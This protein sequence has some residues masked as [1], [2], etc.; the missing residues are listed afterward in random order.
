MA[1]T[2]GKQVVPSALKL[3]TLEGAWQVLEQFMTQEMTA[4]Q[5][6]SSL[7]TKL[8]T[9][10]PS[11]GL[12]FVQQLDT[13]LPSI[14]TLLDSKLVPFTVMYLFMYNTA[15]ALIDE[16]SPKVG[17]LLWVRW[18]LAVERYGADDSKPSLWQ[19]YDSR[20]VQDLPDLLKNCVEVMEHHK[21]CLPKHLALFFALSFFANF[22]QAGSIT[23]AYFS[24][25]NSMAN[26]IAS[27]SMQPWAESST[28]LLPIDFFLLSF[29]RMHKYL[30][31]KYRKSNNMDMLESILHTIA[32][33]ASQK[34]WILSKKSAATAKT[35]VEISAASS[36]TPSALEPSSSQVEIAALTSSVWSRE[37]AHGD[38]SAFPPLVSDALNAALLEKR[39]SLSCVVDGKSLD[40]K[41]LDTDSPFC[42]DQNDALA[43]F[44]VRKDLIFESLD[45]SAAEVEI[46]E[47][48]DDFES[49][50]LLSTP[51]EPPI[52][53]LKIIFQTV[54]S[55]VTS[56]ELT[57][58]LIK[59]LSTKLP[60]LL[61][62]SD[63]TDVL[64]CL[65][66]IQ[67]LSETDSGKERRVGLETLRVLLTPLVSSMLHS[68]NVT[69]FAQVFAYL[70]SQPQ[71]GHIWRDRLQKIASDVGGTKNPES[72]AR[73]PP[74][75]LATMKSSL[76]STEAT[77]Q[78]VE[79]FL[80]ASPSDKLALLSRNPNFR[81]MYA[82]YLPKSLL[83]ALV[84][85]DPIL[86][87]LPWLDDMTRS[88]E[89]EQLL[90]QHFPA[91]KN[92]T[93][94]RLADV[95]ALLDRPRDAVNPLHIALASIIAKRALKNVS[96][97][98]S[99]AL[100]FI[101]PFNTAIRDFADPSSYHDHV[102]PGITSLLC[103]SLLLDSL[104]SF[105]IWKTQ[106]DGSIT[107]SVSRLLQPALVKL[108]PFMQWFEATSRCDLFT[109]SENLRTK[110]L[111][112]VLFRYELFKGAVSAHFQRA[113]DLNVTR[114]ELESITAAI[115]ERE[116]LQELLQLLGIDFKTVAQKTSEARL[117]VEDINDLIEMITA[118]KNWFDIVR[119]TFKPP[120]IAQSDIDKK[121]VAELVSTAQTVRRQLI[122]AG[123]THD[124][125]DQLKS[126]LL[127][128]RSEIFH[129]VF[130]EAKKERGTIPLNDL[131]NL[132]V[133]ACTHLQ[134]MFSDTSP[135]SRLKKLW[136]LIEKLGMTRLEKEL[137]QLKEIVKSSKSQIH[138]EEIKTNLESGAKLD[139]YAKV[140]PGFARF[141]HELP[142]LAQEIHN[143]KP[144]STANATTKL[145]DA[146][147]LCNQTLATREALQVK[148]IRTTLQHVS[149]V[150][151]QL[152]PHVLNFFS[153]IPKYDQLAR[154]CQRPDF[155]NKVGILTGQIQG[156]QFANDLLSNLVDV[157]SNMLS[158]FYTEKDLPA[159]LQAVKTRIGGLTREQLEIKLSKFETLRINFGEIMTY[160]SGTV[161][162]SA[163]A[164]LPTAIRALKHGRYRANASSS[165][166]DIDIA[167]EQVNGATGKVESTLQY[168]NLHGRLRSMT[169]FVDRT[170][171]KQEQI[172]ALDEFK[173]C[174]DLALRVAALH[175][176]LA[177]SGHPAFQANHF[178]I[179]SGDH[180]MTTAGYKALMESLKS[181]SI[182]WDHQIASA[183]AQ[184]RRLL[185]LT[186]KAIS[187]F[188]RTLH[189]LFKTKAMRNTVYEELLPY[190]ALAF[191]EL[192]SATSG[193]L[194]IS[195]K[196][197]VDS[198]LV[199]PS[200]EI[201]EYAFDLENP[202]KEDESL[203]FA[204]IL[205]H[206]ASMLARLEEDPEVAQAIEKA[207]LSNPGEPIVIRAGGLTQI[208]LWKTV[209]KALTAVPHPSQLLY[210]SRLTSPQ[211]LDRFLQCAER[212]PKI[213]FVIYGVNELS[214][215]VRHRLLNWTS[216]SAS[217][218]GVCGQ[219]FLLFTADRSGDDMFG[220]LHS[221]AADRRAFEIP[222]KILAARGI[223][224]IHCLHSE[225]GKSTKSTAYFKAQ[226][227]QRTVHISISEEFEV[228]SVFN[229]LDDLLFA[230][231]SKHAVV[232][233][234]LDIKPYADLAMVTRFLNDWLYFG[235]IRDPSTGVAHY[236]L[237]RQ[238]TIFDVGEEEAH[239]QPPVGVTWHFVIELTN[240]APEDEGFLHLVPSE[241]NSI[242]PIL[243][244]LQS[245]YHLRSSE[246]LPKSPVVVTSEMRLLAAIIRSF[247]G[248]AKTFACDEKMGAALRD[249]AQVIQI[250]EQEF[251]H[252]PSLR[253]R[254]AVVK[255]LSSV[256]VNFCRWNTF[257]KS[258]F[259]SMLY[260]EYQH[261]NQPQNA[262]AWLRKIN[263]ARTVFGMLL[264]EAEYLTSTTEDAAPVPLIITREVGKVSELDHRTDAYQD[265]M[266]PLMP[267]T[268]WYAIS[269]G[270]PDQ[271]LTKR[272]PL[273][274]KFLNS[275]QATQS[276]LATLTK[277]QSAEPNKEF[278]PSALEIDAR[279]DLR[280]HMRTMVA[281]AMGITNTGKMI[282]MLE[283][284]KYVLTPNLSH[285]M[286][287]LNA[288][289]A[290]G[291][292]VILVG[293]T[294]QGKTEMVNFF[295]LFLNMDNGSIPDL[296]EE[297]ARLAC[298][299]IGHMYS[300]PIQGHPKSLDEKQ[301]TRAELLRLFQDIALSDRPVELPPPIAPA[302][303]SSSPNLELSKATLIATGAASSSAAPPPKYV[304]DVR[305]FP[306]LTQAEDDDNMD[307]CWSD[308][309]ATLK[310]WLNRMFR[311]YPL[312]EQSPLLLQIEQGILRNADDDEGFED[313]HDDLSDAGSEPEAREMSVRDLERY[314]STI[315]DLRIQNLFFKQ[316]IYRGLP[317][318]ALTAEIRKAVNAAK[319]HPQLKVLFFLDESNTTA[320][321]GRLKELIVDHRWGNK[322][323]PAN[324]S[325]VAAINPQKIVRT[326]GDPN[327]PMMQVDFAQNNAIANVVSN[328]SRFDVRLQHPSMEELVY[329]FKEMDQSADDEF[330]EAMIEL[331]DTD[332][333]ASEQR[334][335]IE[336]VILGQQQIRNAK[337]EN[338]HPSIRDLVRAM[339]L[340]KYFR[341]STFGSILLGEASMDSSSPKDLT[342]PHEVNPAPFSAHFW[343][344]L[345]MTL[346][347][348]YY[349]RLRNE[350]AAPGQKPHPSTRL[351]LLQAIN[352][353]YEQDR[354]HRR[355]E[356]AFAP[357]LDMALVFLFANTEIPPAIAPTSALMENLF[358]TV[359]CVDMKM[360]LTISGPAGCSKTL[361]FTIAVA[362]MQ[363]RGSPKPL[364]RF[365]AQ[366]HH[367]R[368]QCSEMSTDAEIDAT[369]SE[370]TSRQL[371][372]ASADGTDIREMCTVLLDEL[373]L[374]EKGSSQPLK[375]IHGKLDN[376]QV[377][378]VIL[379]NKLLDPAKTNRTLQVLQSTATSDDL[380][381]LARSCLFTQEGQH[382][383]VSTPY[384]DAIVEGTQR[385]F[386]S[387]SN[388][389][390]NAEARDPSRPLHDALCRLECF[391]LRSFVYFLRS[392]RSSCL[393]RTGHFDLTPEKLLKAILRN[394][395]G[396]MRLSD[397]ERLV[398]F[399]F[400]ELNARLKKLDGKVLPIPKIP[401]T[402]INILQES[403][404][405]VIPMHEMNPN[406]NSCRYI[407]MLDPTDSCTSLDLLFDLG[408]V[409]RDQSVIISCPEFEEDSSEKGINERVMR[410]K[411][412]M[413][414]GE[415]VILVAADGIFGNFYDLFNKHFL[416]VPVDN[417]KE[418]ES[419]VAFF[420]NVA[421][422]SISRPC[423]V[424]P[425]FKVIVHL[426]MSRVRDTP[427]PFLSRFEIY[428]LSIDHY[429]EEKK[430]HYGL[431]EV[432]HGESQLD[433]LI[434]G[435]THFWDTLRANLPGQHP[436]HGM[437]DEQTIFSLAMSALETSAHGT[438]IDPVL[439]PHFI[440]A[441][442]SDDSPVPPT[443][444][445]Y[446]AS[447][448]QHLISMTSFRLLQVAR[449]EMVT[450][451]DFLPVE[452]L[453]EYFLRQEHMSTA[454]L[455]RQL[456]SFA[457]PRRPEPSIKK[458]RKS[459]VPAEASSSDAAEPISAATASAAPSSPRAKK[460]LDLDE[461][462]NPHQHRQHDISLDT[463]QFCRK[464]VISTRS[465]GPL[466]RLHMD[467][468]V[469]SA[470]VEESEMDDAMFLSASSIASIAQFNEYLMEFIETGKT[471]LIVTADMRNR[472]ASQINDL[473]REVDN[474]LRSASTGSSRPV[475][476]FFILHHPP[477]HAQS[478]HYAY[479]AIFWNK[480]DFYYTD[481]LGVWTSEE[482][483]SDLLNPK[484]DL[485]TIAR[486]DA[487][488]WVA[489]S[490]GLDV[491]V[492]PESVQALFRGL[493]SVEF[494]SILNKQII[495]P[496]E[497]LS[498][499]GLSKKVYLIYLNAASRKKAMVDLFEQAPALIDAILTQ[500]AN[501]WSNSLLHKIVE[502]T[503]TD[504]R[505]GKATG[506]FIQ[507]IRN[508]LRFML[509]SVCKNLLTA[510]LSN[511]NMQ[512][513]YKMLEEAQHDATKDLA[514]A[515]EEFVQAALKLVPAP[516]LE[517][518]IAAS[519]LE[520][521]ESG[522]S[523][524][525]VWYIPPGK[526]VVTTLPLFDTV[527]RN[528]S[529]AIVS[530][531]RASEVS[532]I[533]LN[534][535][536]FIPAFQEELDQS[537]SLKD[538][539]MLIDSSRLLRDAFYDDFVLY[540]LE[541]PSLTDSL[542]HIV[543]VIVD[544]QVGNLERKGIQI[545]AAALF[546]IPVEFRHV[547]SHVGLCLAPLSTLNPDMADVES[548]GSQHGDS[549]QNWDPEMVESKVHAFSIGLLW[550]HLRSAT[551]VDHLDTPL[552]ETKIWQW[553]E[554]F[555]D[556]HI[557][558]TNARWLKACSSDFLVLSQYH[559]M[560]LLFEA[561][562]AF[563]LSPQELLEFVK[564]DRARDDLY[565]DPKVLASSTM[566]STRD[567]LCLIRYVRD[568]VA[569]VRAVELIA[570]G[571]PSAALR[572]LNIASDHL[573]QSIVESSIFIDFKVHESPFSAPNL[574][575]N[576]GLFMH[577]AANAVPLDRRIVFPPEI[578]RHFGTQ[579]CLGQLLGLVSKVS[580]D[581]AWQEALY[582]ASN[583]ALRQSY[584]TDSTKYSLFVPFLTAGLDALATLP[585]DARLPTQ[586]KLKPHK[587][588]H[589]PLELI[590]FQ[591]FLK[592]EKD[593]SWVELK[594]DYDSLAVGNKT[595]S[596][597]R[598]ALATSLIMRLA[599][600]LSSADAFADASRFWLDP[601]T[602][603]W[604]KTRLLSQT[605]S[606]DDLIHY[607][608]PADGLSFLFS[609]L[610]SMDAV[611]WFLAQKPL[612]ISMGL[613]DWHQPLPTG[614]Q[615][616]TRHFRWMNLN[617]PADPRYTIYKALSDHLTHDSNG[618]D[619]LI[620]AIR[621]FT[622][623]TRQP[624]APALDAP[625]PPLE[626]LPITEAER[627][628]VRLNVRMVLFMVV[629][630]KFMARGLPCP[631]IQLNFVAT[632]SPI[633]QLLDLTDLELR[634]YQ[635][636]A[637]GPRTNVHAQAEVENH[638]SQSEFDRLGRRFDF[639][640]QLLVNNMS[641]T[642]GMHR[643]S[644][645][646]NLL[647]F[648]G[649]SLTRFT[650]MVASSFR[651]HAD[652]GFISDL[653][654]VLPDAN[655]AIM[656]NVARHRLALN[657]SYWCAY[658]WSLLLDGDRVAPHAM[659]PAVHVLNYVPLK[660]KEG[661]TNYSFERAT[662]YTLAL[663]GEHPANATQS[664]AQKM[665]DPLLY[666]TE[667]LTRMQ[668]VLSSPD[669]D[670]RWKDRVAD[671]HEIGNYHEVAQR[672]VYNI[673]DGQF[674]ARAQT[675][676]DIA[677]ATDSKLKYLVELRS[678][679]TLIFSVAAPTANTI[680]LWLS[681]E[682]A[683]A[684]DGLNRR[685]LDFV[686]AY[687][688]SRQALAATRLL[689]SFVRYYES[690]S[691]VVDGRFT[692]E[693]L[694]TFS[695]KDALDALQSRKLESPEALNQLEQLT[696]A[697]IAHSKMF[698][699]LV[700]MLEGCEEG[701]RNRMFEF[702]VNEMT[703]ET[704]LCSFLTINLGDGFEDSP[705]DRLR[706]MIK[707]LVDL[708]NALLLARLQLTEEDYDADAAQDSWNVYEN[709]YKKDDKESVAL[710]GL[711]YH[712]NNGLNAEQNF[713]LITGDVSLL[714]DAE[715]RIQAARVDYD[716]KTILQSL[717]CPSIY[718]TITSLVIPASHA[719]DGAVADCHV[720]WRRVAERIASTY[721]GGRHILL[722]LPETIITEV[723]PG[724]AEALAA[725]A[726]DAVRYINLDYVSE[727]AKVAEHFRAVFPKT[728][729][730]L[731][732][733]HKFKRLRM[734]SAELQAMCRH[735]YSLIASFLQRNAPKS[736]TEP[737][738]GPSAYE[739][740][741]EHQIS[742]LEKKA[743][744][745]PSDNPHHEAVFDLSGRY[746]YH[747]A[748]YLVESYHEYR[749]WYCDDAERGHFE[750]D[751]DADANA[752]INNKVLDSLD[753]IAF[754]LYSDEA[755][756]QGPAEH[757]SVKRLQ[758][759]EQLSEALDRLSVELAHA[760]VL[761]HAKSL[762]V[763]AP[764]LKLAMS[765][766]SNATTQALLKRIIPPSAN[767]SHFTTYLRKLKII[768]N[769]TRAKRQ[770]I[771]T[772]D[773]SLDAASKAKFGTYQVL[774]PDHFL[775][776]QEQAKN[777]YLP[778]HN[779][780]VHFEAVDAEPT[781]LEQLFADLKQQ[782][783]NEDLTKQTSTANAMIDEMDIFAKLAFKEPLPEED[784]FRMDD[785][786]KPVAE[787]A[788]TLV[789]AAPAP[790]PAG[791]STPA[792]LLPFSRF[793]PHATPVG[794]PLAEP[795]ILA[796]P[797]PPVQVSPPLT[798]SY[799]SPLAT[800][801]P[802]SAATT[803]A[804]TASGPASPSS[805]SMS[806]SSLSS[807]THVPLSASMSS[808]QLLDPT[809]SAAKPI[810]EAWRKEMQ[811][812]NL[813]EFVN[814]LS[815]SII[816]KRFIRGP[817]ALL[818]DSAVPICHSEPEGNRLDLDGKKSSQLH[819]ALRLGH[820]SLCTSLVQNHIDAGT[821]Q[822]IATQESA[823]LPQDAHKTP[824]R[825]AI[826]FIAFAS[827]RL[828]ATAEGQGLLWD[829]IFRF[830]LWPIIMAGQDEHVL[831]AWVTLCNNE[832]IPQEGFDNW[833]TTEAA[834]SLF[835]QFDPDAN[836]VWP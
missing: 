530:A 831:S 542:R 248:D 345:F 661:A 579:W 157:Q 65:N 474:H 80:H 662:R 86:S 307:N 69:L 706:T 506:G 765:A 415:T 83:S 118:F 804:S 234:H 305:R 511:L 328:S 300:R 614:E 189:R 128:Q 606:E 732:N 558:I 327:D 531:M 71:T 457:H 709:L 572:A 254:F 372:I 112:P 587:R 791:P 538:A 448:V 95:H 291:S 28:G 449:P 433:A 314:L 472:S 577:L 149:D 512:P 496:I 616:D 455:I 580:K 336:Y 421:V 334:T 726:K 700:P 824:A 528:I 672:E 100:F 245:V 664:A 227:I 283:Q 796:K 50:P 93:M 574:V 211:E 589:N 517:T 144:L 699:A 188:L 596:V 154:F 313:A 296:L 150:V 352:A 172:D 145:I 185:L 155:H 3:R 739:E 777:E 619:A 482:D 461:D 734:P 56:P 126:C 673:V 432:A 682:R 367:F 206:C 632:N 114:P 294:G 803:T 785:A 633:A 515:K 738:D 11:A 400:S 384:K 631:V 674:E 241:N 338:M 180:D 423:K 267:S 318:I 158:P 714:P 507:L 36:S 91:L 285:K 186:P 786:P 2:S 627:T 689:P 125:Q 681:L 456:I 685:I 768:T 757:D 389:S 750:T 404:L 829:L 612:L 209:F 379:T 87:N 833:A 749:F 555:R 213:S 815:R 265:E 611:T 628:T 708:H 27:M 492:S 279:R 164:F 282:R 724:R 707:R 8:R 761:K 445:E 730:H 325:I 828:S 386:L 47:E 15:N 675:Y 143:L 505:D 480:W 268:D 340:F 19:S 320:Y 585:A 124:L 59:L 603:S 641:A 721:T 533:A 758:Q 605:H 680:N 263:G 353:K 447:W 818:S 193:A 691:S 546:L 191:P 79:L 207:T 784:M 790:T 190:L 136:T 557:R 395:G 487:R 781:Q 626:N 463:F 519:Q 526:C 312:L 116:R 355:D 280:Q 106:E 717:A 576:I 120:P 4:K 692:L 29:A 397:T 527:V 253:Q 215:E 427:L 740:E 407:L 600:A 718:A 342:I 54:A 398:G 130:V 650:P 232:G 246:V 108:V 115:N 408:V 693:E 251:A 800:A 728:F 727:L 343:K 109:K 374:A 366:M 119:V 356:V 301:K 715:A 55:S 595:D 20:S 435:L 522:A 159:L 38:W 660:T 741:V 310:T 201:A 85:F 219:L 255:R 485:Q 736:T 434:A 553:F 763:T 60:L 238:A 200:L 648:E 498:S 105:I 425:N 37:L 181:A 293:D 42:S 31:G 424:H 403:I 759:L 394:F 745:R 491:E 370:A 420:S 292:N 363:G 591:T 362:N 567:A 582:S 361:S 175:K 725:R 67:Q 583:I 326:G 319:E 601:K 713:A 202:T 503:C 341:R 667:C 638:F 278:N 773:Q 575:E 489:K 776:R 622:H 748:L 701:M 169:V 94:P 237:P 697:F 337:I 679:P 793:T 462:L 46:E 176:Q 373:N 823:A 411:D 573:A 256:I 696:T 637:G 592:D 289:V 476:V 178:L 613:E 308:L 444:S 103:C 156:M 716:A 566:H 221:E 324:I 832:F 212:F 226:N 393:D 225:Q 451:M 429:L 769:E 684:A 179:G 288:R 72:L 66:W 44:R 309:R 323:L 205:D 783:Q 258:Q 64:A 231:T 262:D 504:I 63:D 388:G 559:R 663:A 89:Y 756:R 594:A 33:C 830:N 391:Q 470:L 203:V 405:D 381:K 746:L 643:N 22:S 365:C 57:D 18:T 382:E 163:V 39:N 184:T 369:Y 652:C 787:V 481:S 742:W 615:I 122:D 639:E 484:S 688:S 131:P 720:D 182:A 501:Y 569:T 140:L 655:P 669:R 789:V 665:L 170:A 137:V 820:A 332:I 102:R 723:I 565:D 249:D 477:E 228:S 561:I 387:L 634:A 677:A 621:T 543:R 197:I 396:Q 269:F 640:A 729:Q 138:I 524:G 774:V 642:L 199:D 825:L 148:D 243:E 97:N 247:N 257:M 161:G 788:P 167:L 719:P 187:S 812:D 339:R 478:P 772:S 194:S 132:I 183:C 798:Q 695:L 58:S 52:L 683:D 821:L 805:L 775:E 45:N 645:H 146:V 497:G 81:N 747:F 799:A 347:V 371:G 302:A 743:N 25:T 502:S 539:L 467:P 416:A 419:P 252:L 523:G 1:Y 330:W 443:R 62:H 647:A 610:K 5:S 322:P 84:S 92:C 12:F 604:I 529:A 760:N 620:A 195:P 623:P 460:P 608:L 780:I 452:Y 139:A 513:I 142:S 417:H 536:V 792:S 284:H 630:Q 766:T 298:D 801:S 348:G 26:K 722:S 77:P 807:S 520:D 835:D 488:D 90:E 357:T 629:F 635:F 494:G 177:S 490:V 151:G 586:A 514:N 653:D 495:R 437:V 250:F 678:R 771:I 273:P 383:L 549:V 819:I 548:F 471:I 32:P 656:G 266:A 51:S 618:L 540:Q 671:I 21:E 436:L 321:M 141:C 414:K 385:A 78:I 222:Q 274:V 624:P 676:L 518:I 235:I 295:S 306:D 690:L 686:S 236:S 454:N 350:P 442:A 469:Q 75:L 446:H 335:V 409:Q 593:A 584:D 317:L 571:E 304:P 537:P 441:G 578:L 563:S 767:V 162:D 16:H 376:P 822:A 659:T 651:G 233:V 230:Q 754:E 171:L 795:S 107:F 694:Q 375:V 590:W 599:D 287:Q 588:P 290:S 192:C 333:S 735:V 617:E 41:D 826:A 401:H 204:A 360:P 153:I 229:Q 705:T 10:D 297:L 311:E 698:K 428:V 240:P 649:L 438:I 545:T 525:A 668:L 364:Y 751:F 399:V 797:S 499:K 216:S 99:H 808:S 834:G 378:T 101:A 568:S 346:A 244:H 9:V 412:A 61:E 816:S 541:L 430:E 14:T 459:Y 73:M 458:S 358:C 550:E 509:I 762:T 276:A 147:H 24:T 82:D 779:D 261:T 331:G 764:L 315:M 129:L 658:T 486:V 242:P 217:Q 410:F 166:D 809:L 453:R 493:F 260:Y 602:L 468:S 450:R 657:S 271:E 570:E 23:Y 554:A 173:T 806:S 224:A 354:R 208:E 380:S 35:R 174:Y 111:E 316:L 413:E 556:L 827:E 98:A 286:M 49:E 392:L 368:Y 168:H 609:Q 377:M 210:G 564:L 710:A 104:Q 744:L 68:P 351:S 270:P 464:W 406:I 344:A 431:K 165:S 76:A 752:F 422:G 113:I 13:L 475:Q 551:T 552:D 160:F 810:L 7:R 426:P 535:E 802:I 733:R 117:N 220:F 264:D 402:P 349:F 473:R 607:G 704:P 121:P 281:D 272:C 303:S 74:E 813:K 239:V 439:I 440:R 30:F 597:R 135:L 547:L 500:F 275:E 466:V 625:L 127:P 214:H 737:R 516:S 277:L 359:I 48:E 778:V 814:S 96:N 544:A 794:S 508:S 703:L 666:T 418:G 198:F 702:E 218:G 817:T 811:A 836:I 782:A 521:H 479:P 483:D 223:S 259:S 770:D 711:R 6:S 53:R 88:Q 134:G 152:P 670:P 40:F 731:D 110:L 532:N 390:W 636:I 299:F 712:A 646:M 562:R 581:P 510:I 133:M 17:K 70:T 753:V 654:K 644:N 534:L 560:N 755:D 123:M 465:S 598:V 687:L 196:L 329:Y 34:D 43:R